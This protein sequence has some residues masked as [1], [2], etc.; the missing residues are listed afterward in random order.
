[1]QKIKCFISFYSFYQT[2][3][4]SILQIMWSQ[5]VFSETS[6]QY[7]LKSEMGKS[8]TQ[9]SSIFKLAITQLAV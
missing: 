9:Y 5:N 2:T 3:H 7:V 1:M 8:N 6:C 4:T